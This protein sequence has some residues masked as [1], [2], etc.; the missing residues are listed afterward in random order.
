MCCNVEE[1]IVRRFTGQLYTAAGTI[2]RKGGRRAIAGSREGETKLLKAARQ[3]FEKAARARRTLSVDI[4]VTLSF[5]PAAL[6]VLTLSESH[7]L[8]IFL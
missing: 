8:F 5:F 1:E 7:S 3:M 2:G 6:D 4:K